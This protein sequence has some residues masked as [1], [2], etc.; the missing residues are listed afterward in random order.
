MSTMVTITTD[1]PN[2]GRR[3]EATDDI[4][5]GPAPEIELLGKRF[6][7]GAYS[8]SGNHFEVDLVELQA[9]GVPR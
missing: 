7:V 4:E 6:F 5:R 3:F 9:E 1:D 2:L 8:R